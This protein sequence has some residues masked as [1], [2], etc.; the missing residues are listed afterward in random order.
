MGGQVFVTEEQGLHGS[1]MRPSAGI[2]EARV[3]PDDYS[4]EVYAS[5]VLALNLVKQPH[6]FVVGEEGILGVIELQEHCHRGKHEGHDE[7]HREYNFRVSYADFSRS[8][9]LVAHLITSLPENPS[10]S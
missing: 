5:L 1:Q 10:H 8:V 4:H 6:C 7:T 9:K 3:A 2:A